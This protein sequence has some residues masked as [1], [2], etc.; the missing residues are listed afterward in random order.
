MVQPLRT[1]ILLV[2]VATPLAAAD[3][4]LTRAES[5]NY[6]ATSSHADVMSFIRELQQRSNRVRVETLATSTEGRPAI[7]RAKLIRWRSPPDRRKPF[8]PRSAS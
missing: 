2:A 1:L 8:S 7:A 6:A 3:L 5:S 4:P